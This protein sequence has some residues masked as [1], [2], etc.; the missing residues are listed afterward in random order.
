MSD[1]REEFNNGVVG[2]D[3]YDHRHGTEGG[4]GT[5]M[6]LHQTANAASP[7]SSSSSQGPIRM[8]RMTREDEICERSH[9]D[10]PTT[11]AATIALTAAAASSTAAAVPHETQAL[12]SEMRSSSVSGFSTAESW[13]RLP[14]PPPDS[15]GSRSDVSGESTENS[16]GGA[17]GGHNKGLAKALRLLHVVRTKAGLPAAAA[18]SKQQQQ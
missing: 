2:G 8:R 9:D 3:W 5:M 1:E 6:G 16:S 7:G 14:A 11:P 4:T 12:K 17:T 18:A 10:D 15:E 13:S